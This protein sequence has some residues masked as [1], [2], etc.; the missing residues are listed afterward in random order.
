MTG[1]AD[2][3][4]GAETGTE[5]RSSDDPDEKVGGGVGETADSG[6]DE[7]TGSGA[8]GTADSGTDEESEDRDEVGSHLDDV[9]PGC[10]CAEVWEAMSEQRSE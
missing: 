10:G 5:S 3:G 7:T 1:E 6:T 4:V 8:G 2:D 9:D